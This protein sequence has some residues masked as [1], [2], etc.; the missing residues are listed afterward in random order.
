MPAVAQTPGIQ[1]GDVVESLLEPGASWNQVYFM[2]AEPVMLIAIV[3]VDSASDLRFPVV[4]W[5]D[6]FGNPIVST[7]EHSGHFGALTHHGI[8]VY[9][10]TTPGR[11]GVRVHV[12]PDL[13]V[14]VAYRLQVLQPHYLEAN[15]PIEYQM[16]SDHGEVFFMIAP[17]AIMLDYV[18]EE[19]L[20]FPELRLN[21]ITA[22]AELMTSLYAG[23]VGLRRLRWYLPAGDQPM[24]LS[25]GLSSLPFLSPETYFLPLKARFTLILDAEN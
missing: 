1:V 16:D 21:I 11:Y 9:A 6:A 3:E 19:G 24:I 5:L 14:P 4:E 8:L 15:Q 23:G 17:G 25:V 18:Y 2:L 10:A 12:P 20:F 7:R 22:D 13:S